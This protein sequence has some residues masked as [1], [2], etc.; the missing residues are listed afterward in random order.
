M[1]AISSAGIGSGLDVQGIVSQLMAIERQP[2]QRLQFKQ[3]QLETQISAYGQLKS[4]LST[5]KSAMDELGTL[6]A[7]KVFT[8]SSSNPNVIDITASSNANLATFDVEVVRLAENHKMASS[9]ILDTTVFGGAAG[10]SLTIQVGSDV[11][12]TITIDMSGGMT[13]Q[14]IRT[15]LNNDVT[16]PGVHATVINGD[17]NNQKIVFTADDSGTDNALTL[18]YG[19][20]INAATL[21]LQTLNNIGGDTSLLNAEIV[22]DGFNITRSTNNIADV[23]SGVT[24][25]LISASPGTTNTLEINRDLESVEASVQTFADAYNGLRSSIK[26]LRNGQLEA[27]SS[28]LSIERSMLSVLNA[29]ATGGVFSTLSEVGLTLQKDG[30]MSL[31]SSDLKTALQNDFEGVSQLFA[32]DTQGFANRFSTLADNW[33]GS[34]GLLEARTDGLASRVDDLVDRQFTLERNLENV[35]ARF[36]AQFSAL[37]ALVGQLQGTSQFLTSQLAQLPGAGG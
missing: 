24:L 28:L 15:A 8:S 29:P 30:T 36:I 13:L 3:G 1:P 27:D 2:L 6:D 25:N 23:I 14:D 33:I 11:A 9:E 26:T 19:G 10:D 17:N 22:V 37:D 4:T 16:N 12:N 5:F 7:L 35:E 21:N 20:S 18:S 31:S 32:A 34:N